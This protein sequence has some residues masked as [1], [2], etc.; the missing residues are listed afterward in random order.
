M[1]SVREQA[2][3][4]ALATVVATGSARAQ[5]TPAEGEAPPP[6]AEPPPK[7][8]AAPTSVPAAG[9]AEWHEGFMLVPSIGMNTFQGSGA[10]NTGP[11][12]RIGLLAGSRIIELLSLNIGFAFDVVNIDGPGGIPA[13][14]YMFDI[15]FNPLF[16]FPLEKLE[17]LAGPLAGTFLMKG[18]LGSG[19]GALDSWAYGWTVGANA[20]LMF[21]VGSKVKLGG[22]LNFYLRNSLKLCV[23]AN[24]NDT[25][26]SSDI[27][28]AKTL[29]ITFAAVL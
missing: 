19:T 29:A 10:A 16:H 26:R 23:T 17:I 8:A 15:G 12:L 7:V 3:L 1:R 25:C 28:A 11:G 20:G 21:P 4:V 9:A 2:I 24:G 6:A 27:D 5:T 22:L 13:S 18:S 14:E